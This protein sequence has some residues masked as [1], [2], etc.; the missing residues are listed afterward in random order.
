MVSYHP[1]TQDIGGAYSDLTKSL[2]PIRFAD[3]V[4]ML[5]KCERTGKQ[6]ES[7][8]LFSQS[9]QETSSQ[10]KEYAH[11]RLYEAYPFTMASAPNK[12]SIALR[13]IISLLSLATTR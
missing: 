4:N 7:L 10:A 9:R 5:S 1:Q 6:P 8:L 3:I 11:A 12:S 2:K 13:S